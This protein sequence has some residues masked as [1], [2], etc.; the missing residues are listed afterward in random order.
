MQLAWEGEAETTLFTVCI[1]PGHGGNDCGSVSGD[2]WESKDDLVMGLAVKDAL[3]RRNINVV[4][5]RTEDEYVY[6]KERA[7]IAN[8][9]EAQYFLSIH[10]N[11]N[12]AGCGVETWT[13]SECDEE[14]LSLAES[15]QRGLAKVGVQRD[16]GVKH[17]THESA[18][19]DYYVL[20]NTDMPAVLIE[21]GFLDNR[22]DN[23]LLDK[24]RKAYAEAIAQAIQ[25]TFEQYH[26]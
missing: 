8:Q 13:A 22:K 10:R 12:Y 19:S 1:D 11:M 25:D 9:A 7:E 5:T 15:V 18:A 23:E 17:G 26:E 21:L 4:M 20:R 24:N 3:E 16:R 6:L 14:T 2:R